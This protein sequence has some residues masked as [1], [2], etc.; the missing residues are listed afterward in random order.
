MEVRE[1]LSESHLRKSDYLLLLLLC[2]SLYVISLIHYRVLTTHEAVHCQN[3][4]EMFETG[5]WLIPSYGGR[6]WLERPPLPHWMTGF[7]AQVTGGVDQEWALR[8]GSVVFGTIAVLIFGEACA[9][10]FGRDLGVVSAAALATMRE[11]AAYACG[12][13]AD[14]FVASLV[15]IAGSLLMRVEG[16]HPESEGNTFFGR[17]SWGLFGFYFVLGLTNLTKGPLFGTTF[18]VVTLIGV[19]LWNRDWLAIRRYFWC[20]GILTYLVVGAAWP[21]A[22]YLRF[23]DVIDLWMSDYGGRWDTGYIGEPGW[24]YLVQ[25]PWNL[26]P[27]TVPALIGLM[28]TARVV[29]RLDRSMEG[30][31]DR[32]QETGDRGQGT[33]DRRQKPD[34]GF[35]VPCPLSPLPYSKG[36][37]LI[38]AWAILPIV[39]FSLFR[40]KH[41]HYMLSCLAP[42]GVLSAFG[43]RAVW[44]ELQTYP[45]WLRRPWVS[46]RCWGF[47][48]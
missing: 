36:L 11:F 15:T 7:F 40:G 48:E 32:G 23:P 34:L 26:F 6:P 46:L 27:W 4:R 9:R 1:P 2:L 10:L 38:W 3:V 18:L 17:R 29:F 25:Q 39:V 8:V 45:D 30:T 33:E 44:R 42:W 28:A 21:I 43:A 31:G 5:D 20:W 16:I 24:Y 19:I 13:E 41:H 37:R 14:I 12:P 35:N 22:A 47:P